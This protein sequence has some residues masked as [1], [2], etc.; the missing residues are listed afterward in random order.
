M[1]AMKEENFIILTQR[2]KNREII[3]RLMKYTNAKTA[4]DARMKPNVC[5]NMMRKEIK[6]KTS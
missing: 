1:Y 4:A 3:Y 6:I 2:K 5:I